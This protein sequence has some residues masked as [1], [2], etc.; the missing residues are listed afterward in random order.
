[1]RIARREKVFGPGLASEGHGNCVVHRCPPRHA[2][3]D[4]QQAA[5]ALLCR[6]GFPVST[7]S[8]AGGP[9]ARFSPAVSSPAIKALACE[10]PSRRGL[11]A[12]PGRS[13][14]EFAPRGGGE[15][16]RRANQ[17]HH[18]LALGS[19]RTR[20]GPGVTAPGSSRAHPRFARKAGRVLSF[21][22]AVGKVQ[23]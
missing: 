21:T 14:A 1:M 15:R 3:P 23:H 13:V 10:L 5:S 12:V 11:L 4:R 17:W 9:Q 7:N 22:T 20:R 16:H 6:S 8:R 19:A 2:A 18:A